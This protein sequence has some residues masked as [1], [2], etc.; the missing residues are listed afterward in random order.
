[1]LASKISLDL[2]LAVQIIVQIVEILS[3]NITLPDKILHRQI[4]IKSQRLCYVNI[5]QNICH[6][7]VLELYIMMHRFGINKCHW[8]RYHTL[9]IKLLTYQYHKMSGIGKNKIG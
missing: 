7:L 1:M 4:N 3:E 5:G 6:I 2:S 8:R 9:Q